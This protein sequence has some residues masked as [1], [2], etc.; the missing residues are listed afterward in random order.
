MKP[1]YLTAAPSLKN[2]IAYLCED[3]VRKSN[4]RKSASTCAANTEKRT[5]AP[6]ITRSYSD[7]NFQ[8]KSYFKKLQ[9]ETESTLPKSSPNSGEK[10]CAP[11]EQ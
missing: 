9:E 7:T 4:P 10:A 3:S 8:I 5:T 1:T 6:T 2:T 11:S